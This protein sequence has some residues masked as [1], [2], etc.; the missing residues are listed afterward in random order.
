MWTCF[1]R[2]RHLVWREYIILEFQCF[3]HIIDKSRFNIRHDSRFTWRVRRCG[4]RF[5]PS[6]NVRNWNVCMMYLQQVSCASV[7]FGA[8]PARFWLWR[9]DSV[10]SLVPIF[11]FFTGHS[12]MVTQRICVLIAEDSVQ[13]NFNVISIPFPLISKYIHLISGHPAGCNRLLDAGSLCFYTL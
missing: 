7:R 11:H 2:V 13:Y 1:E 12:A 9:R 10:T 8:W 6:K 5:L 3:V 4:H